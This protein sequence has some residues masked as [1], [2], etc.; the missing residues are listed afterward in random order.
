MERAAAA[1]RIQRWWLRR[2]RSCGRSP[3]GQ[4]PLSHPGAAAAAAALALAAVSARRVRRRK[5]S[6]EV[7]EFATRPRRPRQLRP[8]SAQEERRRR[9][10]EYKQ[11]LQLRAENRRTEREMHRR[12]REK[13]ERMREQQQQHAGDAD[14]STGALSSE[15]AQRSSPQRRQFDYGTPS[16]THDRFVEQMKQRRESKER[17]EEL[18]RAREERR[19]RRAAREEAQ[20]LAE[21]E[22]RRAEA[23]EQ[24]G[25]EVR[26]RLEAIE[27]RRKERELREH[28]ARKEASRLR[29]LEPLHWV[30][31]KRAADREREMN[32]EREER[33]K[34]IRDRL[35]PHENLLGEL[36][37]HARQY[38]DMRA[39]RIEEHAAQLRDALRKRAMQPHE[40]WSGQAHA[41]VRQ[42]EEALRSQW[43]KRLDEGDGRRQRMLHYA[44]MVRE[45]RAVR[46][47]TPL[48]LLGRSDDGDTPSGDAGARPERRNRLADPPPPRLG[49]PPPSPGELARQE[50]ER[51]ARGNDY[52]RGAN[53]WAKAHPKQSSSG[54]DAADAPCPRPRRLTRDLEGDRYLA[55][56]KRMGRPRDQRAV[57]QDDQPD[58]DQ[59]VS[60]LKELR[61]KAHRLEY[62]LRDG[63]PTARAQPDC[64]PGGVEE[65]V[66]VN[67]QY[68]D[69]ITAKLE[70]LRELGPA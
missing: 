60:R 50:K 3:C 67:Q 41:L 54:A 52:M 53:Q 68:L 6:S 31:E 42:E 44:G 63:S 55:E 27:E 1:S 58:R 12:R 65:E 11:Y 18:R 17:R 70:L 39:R 28:L 10:E 5:R 13:W 62:N 9:E 21:L 2:R 34:E 46:R 15:G 26:R 25:S 4:S 61:T 24:K 32:Q 43:A 56:A 30:M 35:R 51:R 45:L 7:P 40:H 8:D 47:L 22:A 64:L 38:N 20:T 57:V 69:A 19:R 49:R 37:D 59:L 23:N 33:L 29:R 14:E 36:R 66:A 48:A 16:P